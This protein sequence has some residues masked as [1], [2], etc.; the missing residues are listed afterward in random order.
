[1]NKNLAPGAAGLLPLSASH[2]IAHTWW[3]ADWNDGRN[4]DDVR[5]KYARHLLYDLTYPEKSVLLLA[6]LAKSAGGYES[7]GSAILTGK[8]DP[9]YKTIITG[10]ERAKK[11]LDEIKRFDMPDFVPRPQYIRELKKY[12][13]IPQEHNP[14]DIVDTYELEQKYWSSLWYKP[15]F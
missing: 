2:E 9:R 14:S 15:V 4:P 8:N 6:P 3:V 1:T 10:I 7:C 5:R 11:H 13:I 12:G